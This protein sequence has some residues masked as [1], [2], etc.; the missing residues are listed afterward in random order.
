MSHSVNPIVTHRTCCDHK[1]PE[2]LDLET[3]D[4]L[5][6]FV[7]DIRR[8]VGSLGADRSIPRRRLGGVSPWNAAGA[9]H[10]R[11]CHGHLVEPA[12][13]PPCLPRRESRITFLGKNALV[14]RRRSSRPMRS[15]GC[16]LG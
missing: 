7:V 4:H 14:N 12:Y 15:S 6:R 16:G 13:R 2:P 1:D 5:A 8:V 9:V 11:L 3:K 10:Q